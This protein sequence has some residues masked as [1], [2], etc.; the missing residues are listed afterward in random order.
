M[1][2]DAAGSWGGVGGVSIVPSGPAGAWYSCPPAC[3]PT[4]TEIPP[5]PNPNPNPN[6]APPSCSLH[7]LLQGLHRAGSGPLA[8]P[9][10]LVQRHGDEAGLHRE[11]GRG[12]GCHLLLPTAATTSSRAMAAARPAGC[13]SAVWA[14]AHAPPRRL[15][16]GCCGMLTSWAQ[17]K[18]ENALA[19]M[20][21][22]STP[23]G[24]KSD[25]Y[26]HVHDLP[27]QLG[28][29]ASVPEADPVAAAIDGRDGRSWRLPLAPLSATSLEPHSPGDDPELD[30]LRAAA[31]LVQNREAV[32]KFA[33]RGA[34]QPGPVPVSAPLSDPTAIPAMEHLPE[35][36]AA[37]RHV[38]HALVL[39]VEAKQTSPQAVGTFPAEEG[40][41]LDGWP[42]VAS[43]R[44]LRD[45]VCVPRDLPLPAARSLRA[46]LN[47]LVDALLLCA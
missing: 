14:S 13:S 31:R 45:H 8:Q 42:V 11:L 3:L 16:G 23:Q 17:R 47:W 6:P 18:P 26:T 20:P 40:A 38:A 36:D 2:L 28:G 15:Q 7:R 43:L 21:C 30:A 34:G 24:F 44:H 39:G 9:R 12:H 46:H 33:L 10:A 29:C 41:G 32:T 1:C 22:P 4:L 37:L 25:F 5:P 19:P 35:V 27:P